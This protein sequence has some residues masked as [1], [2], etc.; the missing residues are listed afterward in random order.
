MISCENVIE[1]NGEITSPLLVVNSFCTPDSVIKVNVSK[2]K[3]FLEEE[4][5][6]DMINNA[7]VNVW[8]NGVFKE[9]L[10]SIGNGY[11][12]G[13]YKPEIGDNIKITASTSDFS[14]VSG[15]VDM[16]QQANVLSLD[17]TMKVL[18]TYPIYNYYY[19]DYGR[20]P[21][22][23]TIGISQNV[24]LNFD[25]QIEDDGN[26]INYYRLDVKLRSYLADSSYNDFPFYLY[27]D[28]LVFQQADAG[29]IIGADSYSTYTEFSDELFD[30]KKYT[31][32][33]YSNLY[34]TEYFYPDSIPGKF[35]PG[36]ADPVKSVL[37][38]NLQ[39]ISKS[40]YMY[41]KTL[42]ANSSV[43][44]FF[45]EPVQ[46]FSNVDGGIGVIG[47]YTSKIIKME[48][49]FNPEHYYY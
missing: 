49:P 8:V 7:D 46:I 4:Y 36:Y 10:V 28:D 48:L 21:T 22:Q 30:G 37:I 1:F 43:S 38:I 11:Y 42:V 9:K 47:S 33:F 3:F 16:L 32:K 25:L 26:T 27:S 18:E 17:T 39:S 6:F 40:Y 29:S 14:E 24:Q 41:I 2:S 35:D 19:D 45:S 13:T 15:S 34:R 31:L 23:D 12:T 5:N 20:E 44:E